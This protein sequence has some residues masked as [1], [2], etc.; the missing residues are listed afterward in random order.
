MKDIAMSMTQPRH[1]IADF[2][3]NAG[4]NLHF[5][6]TAGTPLTVSDKLHGSGELDLDA[7]LREIFDA[8]STAER[9]RWIRSMKNNP[10]VRPSARQY[11]PDNVLEVDPLINGLDPHQIF[12]GDM[13]V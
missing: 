13:Q 12:F 11:L 2:D 6:D 8:W 5:S 4:I 7:L 9:R 1:V 3:A 10:L